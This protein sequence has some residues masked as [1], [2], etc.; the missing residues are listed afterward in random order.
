MTGRTLL[1]V[2]AGALLVLIAVGR[3][4]ST[5]VVYSNTYDEPNHI[6]AGMEW[7]ERGTF[8]FE[9]QH[10][11]LGRVAAALGP[12]LAGATIE[13]AR[14]F[15]QAA[16]G[17]LYHRGAYVQDLSLARMGILPFLLAAAVCVWSWARR[18]G[19]NA[20]ALVALA[21]FTTTPL[22]LAHSGVATTD[23][24]LTGT[25]VWALLAIAL[26]LDDRSI[27]NGVFVGATVALALVSKLSALAFVPLSAVAF[28]AVRWLVN[29]QVRHT[30]H[31]AAQAPVDLRRT[32]A[33]VAVGGV[34]ACLVIWSV[35]RFSVGP[36]F[37]SLIP[38]GV[39][40][41]LPELVDGVR[42]LT[43]HT[44]HGHSAFLLGEH[45]RTG[46]WYFFPFG[47]AV[48]TPIAL[49]V[50]TVIG[51]VVAI[52]TARARADWRY[53]APL[54]AAVAIL[55][56]AMTSTINIGVRHVLPIF[57]LIAITAGIGAVRV[58]GLTRHRH[59]ARASVAA[60]LAW[61]V[62]ASARAH[63][64]YLPYFNELAGGHPERLLRDSDLD[65]GQDLL[66]L[67]DTVRAR[68]ITTLNI[69]YFGQAEIARLVPAVTR[70]F[71]PAERPVG[72]IAIS[73]QLLS[74]ADP[75]LAGYRWLRWIEPV[76]QVG[77]SIKLYRVASPVY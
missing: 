41:P 71:T 12:Y 74:H 76:A 35:Y 62:G 72:W 27:R 11:P 60:L 7:L 70:P 73:E 67:A 49:L 47:L 6:A 5:Y 38:G 69:A 77:K 51:A 9:P 59:L 30:G 1:G 36:R 65:W 24:P 52:R 45:R 25:L 56:V 44:E 66:R 40:M 64:D 50:L 10:P 22:V 18:L 34:V 14:S 75:Q 37:G 4:A 68:G 46:W 17:V 8:T 3:V 29:R 48:K 15:G 42:E 33:S 2:V 43:G 16:K 54:A 28:V 26:W 53:L 55:A 61:Q 20:A 23:M 39:P 21:L 31:V 13:D 58:W 63:P 57:P 32:A 19:G